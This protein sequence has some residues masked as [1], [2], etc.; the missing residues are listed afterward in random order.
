MKRPLDSITGSRPL[1]VAALVSM[2]FA[3]SAY[4]DGGSEKMT[5]SAYVDAA[6]GSTLLAGRYADVIGVLGSHGLSFKQD[7]VAA[8]TNLC[9]A[10]IMMH[11]WSDADPA[12]DAAIRFAKLEMPE[13]GPAA[14][15][16]HAQRVAIAYSNRAVLEWLED[17]SGS[18][19]D[20]LTRAHALA[21]GSEFVAQNLARLHAPVR[22]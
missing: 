13:S 10:Y 20:D 1:R 7:E 15:D 14:A 17:R 12:C 22:G 9:V 8:S 3:A 16:A 21:P 6:E 2:W 4:A 18:A 11:R 19:A 5:L